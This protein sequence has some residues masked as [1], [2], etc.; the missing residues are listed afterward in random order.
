MYQRDARLASTGS[1]AW[2]GMEL[3]AREAA[4]ALGSGLGIRACILG[5]AGLSFELVFGFF[6]LLMA[7]LVVIIVRWALTRTK[8]AGRTASEGTRDDGAG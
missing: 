3:M 7:V 5:A 4:L 8:G 6:L 2:L 1:L